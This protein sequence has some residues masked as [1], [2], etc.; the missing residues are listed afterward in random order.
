MGSGQVTIPTGVVAGDP[1]AHANTDAPGG[2]EDVLR[3][4]QWWVIVATVA[5]VPVAFSTWTLDVF[6]LTALTVLWVGAIVAVGLEAWTGG[7]KRLPLPRIWPVVAVYLGVL[8]L[9]TFTGRAPVVSLLGNY[10]RYG[11]LLTVIPVVTLAWL[12]ARGVGADERRRYELLGGIAASGVIGAAYLWA[13]QLGLDVFSWLEPWQAEPRHPPG[14]LGNSNLSGA[15]LAMAA[16]PAGFLAARSRGFSRVVAVASG[17]LIISGVAV[18]Q[19]RGAMLA[20]A[21]ALALVVSLNTE[22]RRRLLT[23]GIALVI[24]LGIIAVLANDEGLDELSGT[25]TWNDRVELW[26]I[27][28]RGAVERPVLGGGPDLYVLTFAD[29]ANA[30]LEGVVAD[31]PHN[32][33]LDHLDGSGIL[34][35]ASWL[36]VVIAVG[37][38]ASRSR[39]PDRVPWMAMGAAYL[40]QAMLSI[41]VVPLYLWGWVAAAGIVG[42]T[43]P[44]FSERQAPE[45]SRPR[46]GSKAVALVVVPV[47]VLFALAPFRADMAQRRGIEASNL[48]DQETA[49]F[50]LEQAADRHGWEARHHRRLGIQYVIAGVGA[51][52]QTLVSLGV[53]ELERTLELFPGDAVALEWLEFATSR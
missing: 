6:N 34:G 11:G 48:G 15:H 12:A 40:T 52:N 43:D 50:Q 10:G 35:A 44:A 2:H 28:L 17:V 41:D 7:L 4:V 24:A 32:V 21:V 8:A 27:A 26:E 13:Q 47:L 49:I 9:T 29:H 39:D 38:T 31:E 51:D 1:E 19:S 46:R 45:P 5:A 53:D 42:I 3:R 25:T 22:H 30:S 33:F 16:V 37:A 36:A 18:S 23:I 14:V 20:V